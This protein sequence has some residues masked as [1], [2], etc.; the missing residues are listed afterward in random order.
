MGEKDD[1]ET[2]QKPKVKKVYTQIQIDTMKDNLAK[3]REAKLAKKSKID[4]LTKDI[5]IENKKVESETKPE[6]PVIK[7]KIPKV[8]KPKV[9]KPKV[10]KTI[11]MITP[12][13]D[14]ESVEIVIEKKPKKRIVYVEKEVKKPSPSPA[15]AQRQEPPKSILRF[16]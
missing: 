7:E 8:L 5:N 3:G 10:A 6:L 4:E 14:D 9:A 1:N 13:S 16:V 11:E 15:P 2:L 12:E